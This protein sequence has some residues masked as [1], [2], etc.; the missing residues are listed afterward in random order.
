MD[1]LD[2]IKND[3][4]QVSSGQKTYIAATSGV[5]K[6]KITDFHLIPST[7]ATK[8]TVQM[9]MK[10]EEVDT[11]ATYDFG[12]QTIKNTDG[13]KNAIGWGQFSNIL[14]VCGVNLKDIQSVNEKAYGKEAKKITSIVGK[15][16][17]IALQVKKDDIKTNGKIYDSHQLMQ[18]FSAESRK[19]PVEMKDGKEP[20]AIDGYFDLVDLEGEFFGQRKQSGGEEQTTHDVVDEMFGEDDLPL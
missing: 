11:G 20:T 2:E 10:V 1:F 5:K 18:V 17:L 4:I 12:F 6:V 14:T 3:D 16:M 19:S 8:K 7:D 9:M 15:E 13:A